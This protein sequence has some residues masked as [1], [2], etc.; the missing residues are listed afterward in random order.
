MK[1]IWT[2]IFLLFFLFLQ[3]RQTFTFAASTCPSDD[4]CK[5]KGSPFDKVT[6]YTD[7]VNICASQRESMAAQVTYLTTKISLTSAKI[8]GAKE[9][10]ATLEK[11]ID[12]ITNKIEGLE[13]SLTQITGL[14]INRVVATYKNGTPSY[15]NLLL[16]SNK[17]ADFFGRLKYIQTIQSHDR[18]LLFQLQNSKVNFEDQKLL[19]EEKRKELDNTKKQLEKEQA[20]LAVQK[21]EKELFLETTKNSESRYK[22]ELEAARKEAEGIQQAASILSQAGVP[23]R[24]SRGEVM[25]IMGNTGFSTGPHLHLSIYNLRESELSKFNFDYGY[26]NPA[27]ILVSRQM[28][29][30][31]SSCD[32]VSTSERTTKQIGGGPWEWPMA[33]PI[34]SQCFGHTP[35]SWRYP[36]GVHN[37]LDMYDDGNPLVKAVES[38]NAYTYRGGQS[39]GNGVFIFHDNGKMTLYWHLQ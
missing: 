12:E 34:I 11:E 27:N 26:E 16:T 39:R 33:N 36:S 24:V 14:F 29:F 3:F 32:D 18:K 22:Q 1:K 9:K 6:C 38:G 28:S 35:W 8:E 7:I 20:T 2:G 37:G 19:R 5:D 21:K 30:D 17:F 15:L 10:I 31:P 25:G 23:K 13:K 4:P